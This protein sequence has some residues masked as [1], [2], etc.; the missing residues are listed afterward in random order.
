MLSEKLGEEL[1]HNR[2]FPGVNGVM[3]SG[4]VV[5]VVVSRLIGRWVV[6][7]GTVVSGVLVEVELQLSVVYVW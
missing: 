3:V 5:V 6:D 4:D 1:G 2:H 7:S